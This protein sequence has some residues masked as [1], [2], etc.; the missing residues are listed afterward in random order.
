MMLRF[1]I[2][3]LGRLFRLAGCVMRTAELACESIDALAARAAG[4]E[5]INP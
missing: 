2:L 3:A 5:N 1:L 4:T